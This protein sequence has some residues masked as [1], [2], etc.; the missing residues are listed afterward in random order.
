MAEYEFERRTCKKTFTLFM[1]ASE[2]RTTTVRRP[3]CGSEDVESLMQA[4]FSKTMKKT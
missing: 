1:R 4:F 2:R 3:E